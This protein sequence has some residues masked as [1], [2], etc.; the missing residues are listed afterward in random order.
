MTHWHHPINSTDTLST[1]VVQALRLEKYADCLAEAKLDIQALLRLDESSLATVGLPL[2]MY[3]EP[4]SQQ[5]HQSWAQRLDNFTC[6]DS[7]RS[8]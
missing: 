4:S 2:G 5:Y 8:A 7:C 3:E 6:A 1:A